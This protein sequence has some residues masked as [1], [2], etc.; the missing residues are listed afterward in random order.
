MIKSIPRIALAAM[1]MVV[2]CAK[3]SA[4]EDPAYFVSTPMPDELA[5]LSALYLSGEIQAPQ[6]LYDRVHRDLEI[7]R[8]QYGSEY[9]VVQDNDFDDLFI[10]SC[11]S[12]TV[13][14]TIV[15]AL[16]DDYHDPIDSLH[17]VHECSSFDVVF[18][19]GTAY[20]HCEFAGRRHP[21]RVLEDYLQL[22][23]FLDGSICFYV[24]NGF[25]TPKV[26]APRMWA[27]TISYLFSLH[28]DYYVYITSTESGVSAAD[29]W[30]PAVEPDPPTWWPEAR[31]NRE[32]LFA[33][34]NE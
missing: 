13:D 10:P 24:W 5:E 20:L 7:I 8:N 15:N 21:K 18:D 26:Y 31:K 16:F 12:A 17:A 14:S 32:S 6:E 22:P 3:P 27:D 4:P 33:W 34:L 2:Y 1:L 9:A 23:G 19:H 30:H 25:D 29:V 11:F 28:A